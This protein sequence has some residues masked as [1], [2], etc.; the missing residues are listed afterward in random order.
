MFW[1]LGGAILAI[2]KSG[3][4]PMS[5][6]VSGLCYFTLERCLVCLSGNSMVKIQLNLLILSFVA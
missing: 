4:Q 3:F 5:R 6:M 2:L 1:V